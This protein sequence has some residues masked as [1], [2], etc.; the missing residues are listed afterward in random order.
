MRLHKPVYSLPVLPQ[1][2]WKWN[3][4]FLPFSRYVLVF[5]CFYFLQRK[6][7]LQ[8]VFFSWPPC[9]CLARDQSRPVIG[10]GGWRRVNKLG[11][12]TVTRHVNILISSICSPPQLLLMTKQ[13]VHSLK[14]ITLWHV[15]LWGTSFSLQLFG[16]SSSLFDATRLLCFL[17]IYLLSA[18]DNG[19]HSFA[20]TSCLP[21]PPR[22]PPADGWCYRDKNL[23]SYD[24]GGVD[25]NHSL[26]SG[27][28]GGILL[29]KDTVGG[30]LL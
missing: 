11:Y 19:W 30:I 4:Y 16:C 29:E 13:P 18:F 28:D 10:R 2:H 15:G 5:L 8:A 3:Y 14:L 23:H 26:M 7:S 6:P 21:P 27:I 9:G 17:W 24:S 1:T 25:R 12:C 22:P 20:K